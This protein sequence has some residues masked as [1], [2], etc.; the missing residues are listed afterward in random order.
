MSPRINHNILNES[1][2]LGF[3]DFIKDVFD[4][5]GSPQTEAFLIEVLEH[6]KVLIDNSVNEWKDLRS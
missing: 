3:N 1:R 5:F 4:M 6:I 2:I